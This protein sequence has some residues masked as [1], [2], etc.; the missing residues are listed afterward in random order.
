MDPSDYY[1]HRISPFIIRFSESFGLRW[2]GISYVLGFV[3]GILLLRRLSKNRRLR[4]SLSE[5]D[6]LMTYLVIGVLVGA[7]VG[8]VLF[9]DLS[10]LVQFESHFPF[11]GLLAVNQGGMSSHGG[12]I[13]VAVLMVIF[14]RRY[15]YPIMHVGDAVVMAA[16]PGLFFGR[17]ANFINGELFGR[18]TDV[19]WAVCFPS[20]ILNWPFERTTRLFQTLS[21]KG[22]EFT[23]VGGLIDGVIRNDAV[24]ALVHPMLTPRHPSQIYEALLEGVVLFLL[25]WFLGKRFRRIGA[26]SAFFFWGYAVLRI[27]A[28]QFREPD[29]GIGFQWLGL[30]RGQW[31]SALMLVA[32]GVIWYFSLKVN[33]TPDAIISREKQKSPGKK[34]AVGRDRKSRSR[35]KR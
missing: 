35:K 23:D 30:T 14:A 17:M 10:L 9:Y 34:K 29:V 4:L 16:P 2:Y 28:E 15:R 21:E 11:W 19:P 5:V 3:V 1:L 7:R 12:F 18:P 27:F 32:G 26:V 6:A 20:E 25:L 24:A 31:L 33:L 22:Y 8:Y 13:G